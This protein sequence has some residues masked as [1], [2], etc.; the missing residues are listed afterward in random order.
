M[1]ELIITSIAVLATGV[2]VSILMIEVQ[3]RA[4]TPLLKIINRQ[5]KYLASRD[6]QVYQGITYS[7]W[8]TSENPSLQ[9]KVVRDGKDDKS[10]E[11]LV[12]D[13]EHLARE[14]QRIEG[15]MTYSAE[16]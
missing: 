3:R 11:D 14:F 16:T 13:A 5:Q 8:Q 12:M 9:R 7:D 15:E 1:T 6:L 4:Q 10:P 2:T